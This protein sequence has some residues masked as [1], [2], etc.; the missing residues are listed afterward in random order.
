MEVI[1]VVHGEDIDKLLEIWH[2]EIMPAHVYHERAIG[3]AWRVFQLYG[4]QQDALGVLALG[5]GQSLHYALYATEQADVGCSRDGDARLAGQD[6][7]S[8]RLVVARV[9]HKANL[10]FG[11]LDG[12]LDLYARHLLDMGR[13]ELGVFPL[14]LVAG[15]IEYCGFRGYLERLAPRFPHFLRQWHYPPAAGVLILGRK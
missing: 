11:W 10:R 13:Q 8:L 15:G 3:E 7:V 2:A 5:D 4:R 6:G 12:S 14:F 9:Q 1:D